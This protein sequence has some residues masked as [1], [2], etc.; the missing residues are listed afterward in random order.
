[1]GKKNASRPFHTGPSVMETEVTLGRFLLWLSRI[2][3]DMFM[4]PFCHS[5][6]IYARADVTVRGGS[7]PAQAAHYRM[8]TTGL[9]ICTVRFVGVLPLTA[10]LVSSTMR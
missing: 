2:I 1:M 7:R 8:C 6:L 3:V 10:M 9:T 5:A 4:P